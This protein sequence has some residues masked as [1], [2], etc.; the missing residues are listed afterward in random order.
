M[1]SEVQNTKDTT[2][3]SAIKVRTGRT[4][5]EENDAKWNERFNELKQFWRDHG[6]TNVPRGYDKNKALG[7][8]VD[9]QRTN[10]R[11]KIAGK[12][13]RAHMTEERIEKLGKHISVDPFVESTYTMLILVN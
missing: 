12:G 11:N 4:A 13:L 6:H 1:S 8:W 5:V 2:F 9:Y 3:L 7:R 10:Y